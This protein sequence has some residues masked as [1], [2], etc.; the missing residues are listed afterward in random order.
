[1]KERVTIG[2]DMG[3]TNT[4]FGVV[5]M[6]GKCVAEGNISTTAYADIDEYINNLAKAIKETFATISDNYVLVGIG[7][8]AP[9]GNYRNRSIEESA[10]LPWTGRIPFC[11]KLEQIFNIPT[12]ITNDAN[13]ATLGEMIYGGAKGMNDFTMITLGTGLGSG[14]VANGRMIY[15]SNGLAGEFGHVIVVKDGRECG[16][17][18]RGC[19][20]TYCSATGVKRTAIELMGTTNTPS[21]LRNIPYN[22][23]TSKDIAQAAQ[24]GDMLAKQVFEITG[25]ILGQALA[26]SVAM[27]GPEAIFLMG[28]LTKAGDL[29]FTPTQQSLDRNLMFLFKNSVKVLPSAI[30]GNVAILGAA[31]LAWSEINNDK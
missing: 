29:L 19:L 2:I 3:G 4:A 15:G 18:R 16:C 27:T 5:D 9:S 13:A 17:G 23:L 6:N 24:N 26:N 14:F 8:G 31:A 30:K 11:D 25:D 10:N 21:E 12:Y 20:E 28:G 22:T 1:M 7:V